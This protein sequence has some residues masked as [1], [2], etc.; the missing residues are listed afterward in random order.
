M[1]IHCLARESELDGA[2]G[3]VVVVRL[4]LLNSVCENDMRKKDNEL[5]YVRNF[6]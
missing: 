4:F 3:C 1:N 5:G 2:T 6:C